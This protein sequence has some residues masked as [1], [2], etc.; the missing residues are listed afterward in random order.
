MFADAEFARLSYTQ[1]E[2]LYA[3]ASAGEKYRTSSSGN[4]FRQSRATV[5]LR[6]YALCK[7]LLPKGVEKTLR[8][9]HASINLV[10]IAIFRLQIGFRG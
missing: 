9:P 2:A 8:A 10:C 7:R 1:Y 6:N 5:S 4:I 3:R